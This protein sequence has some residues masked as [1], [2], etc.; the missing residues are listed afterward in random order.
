MTDTSYLT[1]PLYSNIGTDPDFQELVALFVEE[2]PQRIQ[3]I[4]N[5]L[6]QGNLEGLHH[7]CH[8]LKGSAGGYGFPPISLAADQVVQAIR[9]HGPE[10]QI[11]QNVEYL[12]ALCRQARA[13]GPSSA[14]SSGKEP[15]NWV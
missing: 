2:M 7:I 3:K 11:R 4:L 13:G 5:Y 9:N 6:H 1:Q 8:Q 15:P 12:V 10:E 14:S